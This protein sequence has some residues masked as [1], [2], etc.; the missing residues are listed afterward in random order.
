VSIAARLA[1]AITCGSKSSRNSP[2]AWPDASSS[3]SPAVPS[4]SVAATAGFG[5][6]SAPRVCTA[7]SNG[8]TSCARFASMQATF[9][10]IAARSWPGPV[11][12]ASTLGRVYATALAITSATTSRM[13]F[14]LPAKWEESTP[15][16]MPSRA[17]IRASDACGQPSPAIV[18]AAA[19]TICARRAVSVNVRAADRLNQ[20]SHDW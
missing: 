5:V 10:S 18:S 9:D 1:V 2:L 3:R 20:D 8:A 19:V 6:L 13:R 11:A 7:I 14:P 17:A 15:L 4:Y 16:L 12:S